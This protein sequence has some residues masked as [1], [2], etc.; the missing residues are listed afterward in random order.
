[1]SR[2]IQ[3]R[4]F[5]SSVNVGEVR[6]WISFKST[7]HRTGIDAGGSKLEAGIPKYIKESSSFELRKTSFVTSI[8]NNA[9]LV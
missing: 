4:G 8:D 1:V 6:I 2:G 5:R 9:K 7:D 3:K